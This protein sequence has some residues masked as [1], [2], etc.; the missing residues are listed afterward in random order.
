MR[1][2]SVL[3]PILRLPIARSLCLKQVT[4]KSIAYGFHNR[5]GNYITMTRQFS[6]LAQDERWSKVEA[7]ARERNMH[8]CNKWFGVIKDEADA[9]DWSKIIS[10]AWGKGVDDTI[11]V[12]GPP[13]ASDNP[14]IY[15]IEWYEDMSNR[16]LEPSTPEA[17]GAILE[18]LQA[19]TQPPGVLLPVWESMLKQRIRPNMRSFVAM[20][21][22]AG[23]AEDEELENSLMK[24]A[25]SMPS[26]QQEVMDEA[27][28]NE[29]IMAE[30]ANMAGQAKDAA[31]GPK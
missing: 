15:I 21:A 29:Q 17:Y 4:T 23:D 5:A 14:A 24:L 22:V 1:L 9:D 31:P 8:A 12:K 20:L 19:L 30:L 25:K 28:N 13:S 10:L 11:A 7:L 16:D 2:S 18:A 27:R 6:G 26:L 3:R